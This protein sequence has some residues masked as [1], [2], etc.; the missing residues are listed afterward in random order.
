MSKFAYKAEGELN[1]D[2]VLE[3]LKDYLD[4]ILQANDTK[5]IIEDE[6]KINPNASRFGQWFKHKTQLF[7]LKFK[8]ESLI[9]NYNKV[10][11]TKYINNILNE[12]EIFLKTNVLQAKQI[13]E[14]KSTLQAINFGKVLPLIDENRECAILKSQKRFLKVLNNVKYLQNAY[15][16]YILYNSPVVELKPF[17]SDKVSTHKVNCLELEKLITQF[18]NL[19]Y[20]ELTES[21]FSDFEPKF[22][23]KREDFYNDNITDNGI[24]EDVEKFIRSKMVEKLEISNKDEILVEEQNAQIAQIDNL[25]K[26]LKISKLEKTLQNLITLKFNLAQVKEVVDNCKETINSS[27]IPNKDQMFLVM[28]NMYYKLSKQCEKL[29]QN[30]K[31]KLQLVDK[32]KL[33]D[34]L[35]AIQNHP[36]TSKPKHKKHTDLIDEIEE[37]QTLPRK[38][39]EPITHKST[40]KSILDNL[41]DDD[42]PSEIHISEDDGGD[43]EDEI[44]ISDDE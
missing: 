9:E 22:V 38:Q 8:N 17:L 39:S 7:S 1:S 15:T 18:V 34:M 5:G 31:L 14:L 19:R 3:L 2:Y 37:V 26:Q 16:N 11:S 35:E 12:L 32:Q 21:N 6:F 4:K 30:I 41:Y 13:F 28:D 24:G 33:F 29:E 20:S 23:V 44:I 10:L 27:T 25:L 43:A 40:K 42:E 36:K